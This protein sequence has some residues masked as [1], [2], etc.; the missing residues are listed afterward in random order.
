MPG[1]NFP[2]LK[3]SPFPAI[4]I[5][6]FDKKKSAWGNPILGIRDFPQ[7]PKSWRSEIPST[8]GFFNLALNSHADFSLLSRQRGS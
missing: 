6:D 4:K 8:P 7:I 3:R 1:K 5:F 2:Y